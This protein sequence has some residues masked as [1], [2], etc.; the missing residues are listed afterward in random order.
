MQKPA[1]ITTL[2]RVVRRNQGRLIIKSGD[3]P[4]GDK[5]VVRKQAPVDKF[6]VWNG[7][8]AF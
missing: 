3:V 4:K 5:K 2:I 7:I 6:L 1:E 8:E